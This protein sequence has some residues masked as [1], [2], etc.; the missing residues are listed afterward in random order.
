MKRITLPTLLLSFIMAVHS[1]TPPVKHKTVY[2]YSLVGLDG[3]EVSLSTY[4]GKVLLIVNLAS[5]S[6]YK[7][8]IAAL[9]QLQKAYVDKGLV[10]IGIPS[11]DFSTQEPGDAAAIKQYYLDTQ[12]VTFPIYAKVPLRGKDEI[13]LARFLTD[14][15][16]SL[17]GGDIHWS[18]TKFLIDRAGKPVARFEVDSDPADPEFHV[19]VE[20]VLDGS[21][22]KKEGTGKDGSAPVGRD[23]DDDDV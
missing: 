15:K 11:S 21:Y 9:E 10:L 16:D 20:Q 3:K 17:P 5:Q 23:D 2:D 18:F 14:P 1:G 6:I 7:D 13:P 22:K 19:T 12:H 8:Q 4:K